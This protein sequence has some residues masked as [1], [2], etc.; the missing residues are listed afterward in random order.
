M[1]RLALALFIAITMGQGTITYAQDSL[2]GTYTGTYTGPIEFGVKLIIASVANGV[3]K[4]TANVFDG[5]CQGTYPMEGKY[6][7]N[8]LA[9]QDKGKG[10]HLDDCRF[11]FKAVHE[12]NKLVGTINR[13]G[14][15]I[16][17]SK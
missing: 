14:W 8:K 7:G 1:K 6:D 17:M 10:D 15:P 12:G 11:G 5:A 2:I 16:E 13:R 4:G 9:M 3:V